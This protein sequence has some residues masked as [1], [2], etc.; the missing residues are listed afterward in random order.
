[1]NGALLLLFLIAICIATYLNLPGR[2]TPSP[3]YG[4]L[5]IWYI[6]LDR[7]K[8]RNESLKKELKKLPPLPTYRWRAVDGKELSEKDI[9]ALDVPHWA[10]PD[11]APKDKTKQRA[12]EIACFLSHRTLLEHL[13][14]RGGNPE[15]GHLILEDDIQIYPDLV[16]KWN[17]ALQGLDRDWD[18]IFLGYSI[19]KEVFEVENNLGVPE[20]LAGT[21]AYAVKHKSIPKILDTLEVIYDPIDEVYSREIG[22]LN[23]LAF[24]VPLVSPGKA[25]STIRQ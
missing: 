22:T 13:Q 4:I 19:E 1:M 18:M 2:P 3:M 20:S 12:N 5:D 23:I 16:S 15:D 14:K 8:D 17:T 11:F 9:L 10:R 21:Y 24:E 25:K 6:N 7:S